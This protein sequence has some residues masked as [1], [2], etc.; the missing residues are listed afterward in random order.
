MESNNLDILELLKKIINITNINAFILKKNH[1]NLEMFDNYFRMQIYKDFSY[2]EIFETLISAAKENTLIT[3]TDNFHLHYL[4]LYIPEKYLSE[5]DTPLLS[6]GPYLVHRQS[7]DEI[8]TIMKNNNIPE[9]TYRDIE[10]FYNNIPVI[11][12]T[13]TM[14]EMFIKDLASG[15]FGIVYHLRHLPADNIIFNKGNIISDTLKEDPQMVMAKIVERYEVENK[16]MKALAAGDYDKSQ[17]IHA[18]FIT[19]Y[20]RP[21]AQNPLRNKQHMLVILNTLCRKAVEAGGVHPLYIDE[22]STRFS[23]MI[24]NITSITEG[25]RLTSEMIHKYCLLVKNY[26]MKG[27]SQTVKD[28]ILYIDFNY[29]EDINLNFFAE[30]FNM[31]K[32]YLSNLFRKETGATLTDFIHQIRMRK[33]I[34]L[35]NSSTLPITD[36]ATA[37]G[38]NDINYFTRIFK[39]TYG[40]SPKQYHKTIINPDR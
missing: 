10:S 30:K 16:L 40:L 33:A 4:L 28:I 5:D 23:V 26:A 21:R 31:S 36:I 24:N 1:E 6:I 15:I 19:Y 37:C 32:T 13:N 7:S 8:Y 29:A 39:R 38:Y 35:I 27:Y 14:Y 25:N 11:M 20:I 18:K 17:R 2:S 34:T 3:I 9:H 22:L 12:G